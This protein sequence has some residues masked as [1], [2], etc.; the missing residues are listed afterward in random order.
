MPILNGAPP[1]INP[2]NRY[3]DLWHGCT[4][5]DKYAIESNGVDPLR[6]RPNTDFGRGFYTTT[7]ERQARHWAWARYYDPRFARM[8]G[9][10]PV[11]LRFT[12]DRHKL[13]KFEALCF[14]IGDYTYEDFWSL[15]QHCRQSTPLTNPPPHT[16]YDHLG[17]VP[18]S[19]GNWYDIAYG[20]VSAFWDQRSAMNDADQ[21]SFHTSKA[22]KL[23]TDLINSGNSTD[24]EWKVVT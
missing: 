17:P 9:V 12:V 18:Q 11:V 22:A 3:L 15:V 14:L 23:L 4:T 13:A 1:W 6:G 8:T 19:G 16:V 5:I 21:I 20:P 24:Y 10:Q 2:R 7:L